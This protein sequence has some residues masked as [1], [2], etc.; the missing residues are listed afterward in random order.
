M[1][2]GGRKI[3]TSRSLKGAVRSVGMRNRS[4]ERVMS[5][6]SS[7]STRRLSVTRI[8]SDDAGDSH[9][10]SFTI[11]MKG[12]GRHQLVF[13]SHTPHIATCCR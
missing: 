6:D 3:V 11:D 13:D 4:S 10:G 12:S 5:S 9:F 8:Y 1:A 7:M 2:T